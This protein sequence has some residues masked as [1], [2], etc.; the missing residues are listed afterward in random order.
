MSDFFS[1][2]TSSKDIK[3]SDNRVRKGDDINLTAKDPALRRIVVGMGWSLNAFNVDALD[4]DASCF[5]L[6]KN[7][8][9]REDTD[10]VFYNNAQ[11]C[12]K[13]VLHNG[14]SR[15]GAGEGDDESILLD[16]QGIPFDIVRILFVISIYHAHEKE[17]N[18]GMVRNAYV[19]VVNATNM[20]EMLRYD[21]DEELQ[22]RTETAMVVAAL[23]REGPKWHMRPMGEFVPGGL[24]EVATRYGIIV[25]QQE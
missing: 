5:L 25:A 10:F 22:D 3:L 24:A 18:M 4:I 21:L 9:T 15:S 17:Q 20:H 13:A 23:D 6:D 2:E 1:T 19:R 8:Q 11:A 7:G 14:D 12:N 16:L